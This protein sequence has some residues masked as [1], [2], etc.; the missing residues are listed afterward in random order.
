MKRFVGVV[1]ALI[2]TLPC[3]TG[4]LTVVGGVTIDDEVIRDQFGMVWSKTNSLSVAFISVAFSPTNSWVVAGRGDNATGP[5]VLV[6][7]LNGTYLKSFDYGSGFQVSSVSI[8][9][10]GSYLAYGGTNNNFEIFNLLS[11]TFVIEP[12]ANLGAPV[13]SLAFSPDG[14]Y[15]AVG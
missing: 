15:L 9:P 11:G 4:A 10:N 12:V 3:F 7:D 2:A 8:S 14:K 13:T 1:L 6:Y 5:E